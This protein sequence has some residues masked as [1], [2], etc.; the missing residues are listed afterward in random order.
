MTTD[1][2]TRKSR[3]AWMEPS[4]AQLP[5]TETLAAALASVV[6]AKRRS[7]VT[8]VNRQPIVPFMTFPAEIVT[9]RLARGNELKLFCKYEAGRNH[10]A[11][12]HRGG[13][14]YE[15]EVH[16]RVLQP[17]RTT[18]PKYF[19]AW[20]DPV[21][22]DT[23][24]VLAYL[25]DG[26][27]LRDVHLDL[28]AELQ[29]TEMGLAARWIGKFHAATAKKLA[30]QA[31]AFLN[32]YD[33][34]YYLGWARRSCELAG[35]LHQKFPWLAR[36][37]QRAEEILTALFAAPPTVI[38]GEYYQNN[39][40]IRER[41]VCPSDWESAAIAAGE[42]DLAALTEGSWAADIV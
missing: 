18:T 17:M 6:G 34:G 42:I 2:R 35:K 25:E 10:N 13:V 16:R 11:Y 14:A 9:C 5:E 41:I 27:L 37:C 1:V 29:P 30:N 31:L 38:H 12:G 33:A 15:A 28:S 32:R 21:T 40:L 19:G 7:S 24:L 23:W 8:I 26:R 39:I 22:A 20:K 36:L 3:S 4:V